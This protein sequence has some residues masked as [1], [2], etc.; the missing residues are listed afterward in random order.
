[1]NSAVV[2]LSMEAPTLL[3]GRRP[4]GVAPDGRPLRFGKLRRVH[5]HKLRYGE[6]S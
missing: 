6:E 5:M 2:D 4:E 1:M 3:L